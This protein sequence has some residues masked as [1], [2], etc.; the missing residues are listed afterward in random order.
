[1]CV[2]PQKFYTPD[3]WHIPCVSGL[4]VSMFGPDKN[5]RLLCPVHPLAGHA[6]M[7]L[8]NIS[9]PKVKSYYLIMLDNTSKLLL[10][11]V[12]EERL[13]HWKIW[14][15]FLWLPMHSCNV[16]NCVHCAQQVS[17]Y[18][19]CG[20]NQTYKIISITLEMIV[21][22]RKIFFAHTSCPPSLYGH[23]SMSMDI[24][25]CP[26]SIASLRLVQE[27]IY[28]MYNVAMCEMSMTT[29]DAM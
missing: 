5:C 18:K 13:I 10:L 11:W 4:E 22:S 25:Q 14:N 23:C 28:L 24:V 8:N 2:F 12:L 21:R 29:V 17:M 26:M 27:S 9:Y 19:L 16:I 1:M 3:L 20:T 6:C 15:V 7:G